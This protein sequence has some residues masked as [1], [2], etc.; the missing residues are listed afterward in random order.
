MTTVPSFTTQQLREATCKAALTEAQADWLLST[1]YTMH[2]TAEDAARKHGL[3]ETHVPEGKLASKHLTGI[4]NLELGRICH[5]IAD[6]LGWQP[7]PGRF[8]IDLLVI[9]EDKEYKTD[10]RVRWAVRPQWVQAF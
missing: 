10:D 2:G 6:Q 9:F 1:I 5:K 7:A 4:W 8:W 3:N